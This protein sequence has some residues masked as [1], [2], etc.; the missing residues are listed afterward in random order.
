MTQWNICFD[1]IYLYAKTNK[2]FN[3]VDIYNQATENGGFTN[4]MMRTLLLNYDIDLS[5]ITQA[6]D[7]EQLTYNDLFSLNVDNNELEY[8]I[9][10]GID[11]NNFNN[12]IASNPFMNINYSDYLLAN[13]DNLLCTNNHLLLFH[14]GNL[15]HNS[16]YV[17]LTEDL[18]EHSDIQG[19]SYE[20]TIHLYS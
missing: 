15:N 7:K 4:D 3:S 19:L 18:L 5:L 8:T 10:I 11:Y 17:C 9:P 13:I 2:L 20:E 16:L 1:E 14:Y 6:L 12:F